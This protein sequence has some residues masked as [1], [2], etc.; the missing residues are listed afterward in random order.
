MKRD[1][2]S[3]DELILLLATCEQRARDYYEPKL[4]RLTFIAATGRRLHYCAAEG[5]DAMT[6][7][8]S[9]QH[10]K[11]Q[12]FPVECSGITTCKSGD[13]PLD[14]T[15]TGAEIGGFCE[16]HVK[17]NLFK[18]VQI[19]AENGHA[20]LDRL[21]GVCKERETCGCTYE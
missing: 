4:K 10:N 9:G 5:C 12:T 1:R 6:I 17:G 13:C 11:W 15:Y 19:C 2:L 21:C 16:K 18:K 7:S 3:R 20:W 8:F 14:Q